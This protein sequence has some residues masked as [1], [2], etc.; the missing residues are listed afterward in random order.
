MNNALQTVLPGHIGTYKWTPGSKLM[1]IMPVK[2]KF[3][4]AM[5]SETEA[6][7][8]QT[9]APF[10]LLAT[11]PRRIPMLHFVSTRDWPPPLRSLP[12]LPDTKRCFG[13]E[14]THCHAFRRDSTAGLEIFR[15]GWRPR[16]LQ[17]K[18]RH[19]PSIRNWAPP[20]QYL[21]FVQYSLSNPISNLFSHFSL[22]KPT[23]Y[24]PHRGV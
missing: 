5:G 1:V 3:S 24:V 10:I 18:V 8:R 17:C 19:P 2:L 9:Q 13:Y 4:P 20:A 12:T 6:H 23:M 15:L 14:M 16:T 11:I 7:T 21:C 22:M